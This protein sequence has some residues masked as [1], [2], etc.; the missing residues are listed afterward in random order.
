MRH[1]SDFG[2]ADMPNKN[3]IIITSVVYPTATS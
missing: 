1:S 3:H 2:S